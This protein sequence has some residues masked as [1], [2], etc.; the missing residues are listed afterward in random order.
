MDSLFDDDQDEVGSEIEAYCPSP[1]CKADTNHT[2]ISM[3]EDEIRRVQCQVCSDVHA[4]RKPRGDAV[5]PGSPE[6]EPV[7]RRMTRKPSWEQAMA[8]VTEA[9]L[10]SCRPYSIRDTYEEMDVVSHPKFGTGFV[11]D[12]LPD[13]KVEISFKD[14]RRVLVHNRSDLATKMPELAE[15]PAPRDVKKRKRKK[16]VPSDLVVRLLEGATGKPVAIDP[17][18]TAAKL[19]AAQRAAEE[20]RLMAIQM[21]ATGAGLDESELTPAQRRERRRLE[22]EAQKAKK[23]AER[24]AER[25]KKAAEREAEQAK[26]A[27]EREKLR[28]QKEKERERARKKAATDRERAKKKAAAD[29]ERAKKKATADRERARKAADRERA[30]KA[31]DR[32]RAKKAADRERAK[33][34]ADRERAKKLADRERAKKAAAKKKKAAPARPSKKGAAAKKGAAT[35][36]KPTAAASR[37]KKAAAGK[38]KKVA[39]KKKTAAAVSRS[40]KAAAGKG[41]KVAAKKKTAAARSAS[42]GKSAGKPKAKRPAARKPARAGGK[43]RRR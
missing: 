43:S 18:T 11:T 26:K 39:A 29:R 7:R 15:M 6:E 33:K 25:A 16:K 36:K 32:E 21:V 5:E 17:E 14:E 8:Q 13:N 27:V 9:E 3:Y 30:K 12:L 37:S 40:K 35:K 10:A 19:A 28:A 4:Y 31:A 22:R 1:R 34:L 42:R 24:E 20:K 2:V 23:A 41:K 38:G